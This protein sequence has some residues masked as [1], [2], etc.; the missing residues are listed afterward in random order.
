MQRSEMNRQDYKVHFLKMSF[1][2][3]PFHMCII[4]AVELDNLNIQIKG[5]EIN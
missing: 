5:H 3:L 2:K 1:L 4:T